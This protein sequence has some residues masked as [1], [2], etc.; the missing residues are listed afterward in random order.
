M[1][2][3]RVCFVF[4]MFIVSSLFAQE[5]REF[6]IFSPAFDNASGIPAKYTCEGENVSPPL[7]W[8]NVPS[9]AKSLLL[10]VE[11]PDAPDPKAPK[12][13][14]VHWILYNIPPKDGALAENSARQGLP[15]GIRTGK[16]SWGKATYGGPCPPIGKHRYFFKLYALKE[17]LK[18]NAPPSKSELLETIKGKIIAETEFFGTYEK[19]R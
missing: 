10:I 5:K 17:N 3:L 11:D 19:T 7:R 12:T 18:F 9:E 14:W 13:I 1:K 2:F 6:E 8:K 15:Q 16:N 4:F